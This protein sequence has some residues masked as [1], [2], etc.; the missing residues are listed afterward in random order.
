VHPTTGS[1]AL[2]ADFVKSLIEGPSQYGML[3]E[4]SL[5]AREAQVHAIAEGVATGRQVPE[6]QFN[7]F[8]GGDRADYDIDSGTGNPGLQTSSKAGTI[9][10][11]MRASESVVVGA[12]YG[13]SRNHGNFGGQAGNYNVSENVWSVFA[14][15]KGDWVYGTGILSYGDTRYGDIKRRI[16]IGPTVRSA[17]GNTEGNN[18]SAY[19]QLGADFPIG[20]R[21]KVGPLAAVHLQDVDVNQFDETGAGAANLR[22]MQQKRKSEV[23]SLGARASYNLGNWT[24]WARV[25]ADRERRDEDRDV[26]AMPLTMAAIG[27]TYDVPT[28][29]PDSSYVTWS[30]GVSGL[31][32]PRVGLS[33]AYYRV[34]SRSN[35]KE[36]GF[37]GTIS[38][39]F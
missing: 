25:T 26:S 6:G 11:T 4:A 28:Y 37:W 12:A 23:W 27:S 3:A 35:A 18:T 24:P 2:L 15:V 5:R 8:L 1:H 22:I 34:E 13:G 21:F 20:S 30:A 14:S 17:E 10:I 9:G 7:V 16:P 32:M 29:K 33:L 39:G 36:D 19:F 31:I 38:F